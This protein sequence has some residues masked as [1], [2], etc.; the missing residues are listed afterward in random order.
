MFD[1]I[2][3]RLTMGY[4]G[5]LA[6][7]L[8]VFG[9]VVVFSFYLRASQQQDDLLLQKAEDKADDVLSGKVKDGVAEATTRYDVAVIVLLPDGSAY[10]DLDETSFLLGLPNVDAARRA[11]QVR[12]AV[13]ETVP[14][15]G[16]PVRVMTI[17][18]KRHG[19]WGNIVAITQAAQS[20]RAVL[21]PVERLVWVLVLTGL[22]A[23]V[24]AAAGGLFMSRRAMR[25]VQE[26]FGRQRTFIADASHELKTPLTLIR[27]DAEVLS[28]GLDNP[29][30]A[31]DN[32]ELVDDLLGETDR[33]SAILSD[34][35]LLARLDA[36]K[37]SVSHKPFDLALV[38]SETSERFAARAAAEGKHLEVE[39]SGKLPA[40]GDAQRTG[41]ILAALLDN[42]LRFTPPEG[43]IIVEGN[44]TDKR[45]EATVADTGPGIPP[46]SLHRIFERFYR[47]DTHSA[48]RTRGPSGGGTG[49]GL[50]IARDLARAQGGELVAENAEKGGARFTLTLPP[51]P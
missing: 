15:P 33:M 40:R 29:G 13:S 35:L 4:V 26:A 6:L 42:A 14:G 37:V 12:Q 46:D 8:L 41:Q 51:G 44:V 31:R 22:G 47:A 43:T 19:E 34:L 1:Q 17:P 32:R 38:L 5:I 36:E 45:I 20:R 25:P 3:K 21:D 11:A 24:L 30:N 9:V 28:R 7:I 2:R 18:V 48:A 10:G 23:L 49:L 39:H 27:A 50:A 16:G